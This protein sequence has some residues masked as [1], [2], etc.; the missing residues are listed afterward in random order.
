MGFVILTTIYIALRLLFT[1]PALPYLFQKYPI[2]TLHLWNA[3]VDSQVIA[4][5]PP[6]TLPPG[7]TDPSNSSD[8]QQ[9]TQGN[10]NGRRP[11]SDSTE[12]WNEARNMH[13]W[14][15]QYLIQKSM[16]PSYAVSVA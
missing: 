4:T 12:D 16:L 10:R 13:V 14:E 8:T 15:H 2:P 5:M 11:H 1:Y 3:N 6:K 9:G 7:N